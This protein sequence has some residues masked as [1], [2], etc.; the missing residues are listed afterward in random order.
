MHEQPAGEWRRICSILSAPS[1]AL[2]FLLRFVFVSTK[3]IDLKIRQAFTGTV[4]T[5]EVA[6]A[7]DLEFA[8]DNR[9]PSLSG[10]S[11]NPYSFLEDRVT[12]RLRASIRRVLD[13]AT[14]I[15]RVPHKAAVLLHFA[16]DTAAYALNI[17]I[18]SRP[19]SALLS[20]RRGR[21]GASPLEAFDPLELPH[22]AFE[23][24]RLYD[25]LL[26]RGLLKHKSAGGSTVP[27]GFDSS[28]LSERGI[29]DG[30]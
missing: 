15:I 4:T 1:V 19:L 22:P 23:G 17:R 25:V 5:P 8:G 13:G 27:S 26:H 28:E 11:L 10:R 2:Q 12:G 16:D 24:F 21:E 20:D 14:P 30:R 6:L 9:R 3:N 7:Y 29:A 18:A